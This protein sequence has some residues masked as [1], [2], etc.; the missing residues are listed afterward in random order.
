MHRL[1]GMVVSALAIAAPAVGVA[2]TFPGPVDEEIIG[3][4]QC[5]DTRVYITYLG[6][7]ELMG[8]GYTAGLIRAEDG[9]LRIEWDRD[10][11]RTAWE[12]VTDDGRLTL[13]P[14]DARDM[15]CDPRP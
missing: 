11:S 10:G 7:I 6:S 2:E 15:R 4:W 3:D 14:A 1:V 5:G 8:E 13:F 9:E 12:Y